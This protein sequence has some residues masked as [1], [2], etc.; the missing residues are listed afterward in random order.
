MGRRLIPL[1]IERGHTIRALVRPGSEK[2][3][4]AGCTPIPGNALDGT[5]HSAEIAPADTFIQLVGVAHSS[6]AIAAEFPQIDLPAGLGALQL[7]VPRESGT[8][9]I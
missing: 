8:S 2:K 5:S 7:R 4:P 3:L 9:F 6:P 1:L